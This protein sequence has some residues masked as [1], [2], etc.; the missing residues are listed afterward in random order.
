[1]KMTQRILSLL[2]AASVLAGAAH[3]GS[4]RIFPTD[5]T[6]RSTIRIQFA[7]QDWFSLCPP[8]LQ[9][10]SVEGRDIRV[11]ADVDRETGCVAVYRHT[12]YVITASVG[13]LP[14]G[15]YQV[16]FEA[17]DYLSGE[18]ETATRG[19]EVAEAL[20]CGLSSRPAATV[21]LPYFEVDVEDPEGRDTLFTV[22]TV[23]ARP[24]LAHAVVW[25]NRGHPV[26]SFDFFL[27]AG[28]SRTFDVR[29]LLEGGLPATSPPEDPPAGSYESCTSP[30]TL[31]E[32]DGG[33]LTALVAG[34]PDPGDG[35]CY[36]S[37]VEGGR[38]ATGYV[39]VDVVRDCSGDVLATPD[40]PG[41]FVDGGQGLATNDN[42]LLG[43]FFL[44]DAAN[45][46]AQGESLV[47]LPA[48]AARF[49]PREICDPVPCETRNRAFYQGADN[50]M[51]LPRT[52]R[53]R[54]LNGGA[55]TGGTDLVVW[56][57]GNTGLVDCDSDPGARG[58]FNVVEAVVMNQAGEAEPPL[59]LVSEQQVLR[60]AVGGELLLTD[61]SFG[62]VDVSATYL[63]AVIGVLATEEL[64]IW[65]MPLLKASGRFSAG[66][67]AVPVE[68]FCRQ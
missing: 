3:A 26:L 2:A 39:T 11:R 56:L 19:F 15:D 33:A 66:F 21:L 67:G 63:N 37:A 20:Q 45:D 6:S 38:V 59:P 42:V 62:Y 4:L 27:P 29:R 10:V 30:L 5:P 1:M 17:P 43:D 60:T 68:D 46:F 35:N 24:T 40:Q 31:P 54:F 48:D 65:A 7:E 55:F 52:F 50:R 57:R 22:A 64:Q 23:D 61:E 14:P 34:R 53:S 25:T 9:Q 36:A 32:V 44:I 58:I 49:G 16:T 8:E 13:P 18:T 47:S 51:P 28:G 41:Y 12:P